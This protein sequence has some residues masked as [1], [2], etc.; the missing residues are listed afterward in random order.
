MPLPHWPGPCLSS[1]L[2]TIRCVVTWNDDA[3]PFPGWQVILEGGHSVWHKP[4]LGRK[5]SLGRGPCSFLGGRFGLHVP[6]AFG[7]HVQARPGPGQTPGLP[8][9]A[10]GPEISLTALHQI[11]R[12]R[13]R[14]VSLPWPS[15][16]EE[17]E[18]AG[19]QG[20]NTRLGL[21]PTS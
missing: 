5:T 3:C 10:P 6:P 7:L 11:H 8:E 1:Y 13:A 14:D 21:L 20:V 2:C 19:V 15:T 4:L 18:G 12:L 9:A 16:L 17:T